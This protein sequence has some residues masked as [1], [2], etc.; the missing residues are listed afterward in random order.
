MKLEVFTYLGITK[1]VGYKFSRKII[2][3][4]LQILFEKDRIEMWVLM[5]NFEIIFNYWALINIQ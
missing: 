5:I 4:L 1:K 3:N 2:S